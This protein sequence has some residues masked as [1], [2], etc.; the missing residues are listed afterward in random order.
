[1][2]KREERIDE[3]DTLEP[4][5]KRTS[6]AYRSILEIR[7]VFLFQIYFMSS[8]NLIRYESNGVL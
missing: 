2:N 6:E 1:M 5:V 7:A 4:S 8:M 3:T